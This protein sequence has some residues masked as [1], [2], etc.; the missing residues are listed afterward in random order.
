VK[1]QVDADSPAG[2][3]ERIGTLRQAGYEILN[4]VVINQRRG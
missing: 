4:E 2:A 1:V 3:A